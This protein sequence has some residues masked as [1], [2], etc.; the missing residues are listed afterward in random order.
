MDLPNHI[1]AYVGPGAGLSALGALW[2]LIASIGI[3]L[4]AIL[5]WPIRAV[6]RKIRGPKAPSDGVEK[7]D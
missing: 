2:A 6:I 4:G 5:I 7:Q 1:I 3:A